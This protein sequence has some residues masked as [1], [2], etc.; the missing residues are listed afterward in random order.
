MCFALFWK[1]HP[2][3]AE[4]FFI[5]QNIFSTNPILKEN[6]EPHSLSRLSFK[7]YKVLQQTFLQAI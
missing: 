5:I 2:K 3:A 6:A 1:V 4:V 7:L